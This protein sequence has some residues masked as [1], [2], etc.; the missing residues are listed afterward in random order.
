M[1][2]EELLR[3]LGAA[4]RRSR[5]RPTG[6]DLD[7]PLGPEFEARVAQRIAPS[8]RVVHHPRMRKAWRWLVP[9]AA[10]AAGLVLWLAPPRSTVRRTATDDEGPAAPLPEYAMEITGGVDVERALG[11]SPRT[12][13]TISARPGD[14]LTVVLRPATDVSAPVEVHLFV[15]Q[16]QALRD[17]PVALR[18]SA[19]GSV[20]MRAKTADLALGSEADVSATVVLTRPGIDPRA[21]DAPGAVVP[22]GARVL[23]LRV[24]VVR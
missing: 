9:A 13:G 18:V 23:P 1:N 24:R 5:A 22:A 16:G 15:A 2:D 11:P 12:P 17:V 19:A 21:V 6:T 8:G 20:E 4:A 3:E 10:A 7:A 14:T